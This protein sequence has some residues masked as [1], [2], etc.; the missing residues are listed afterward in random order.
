MKRF[1][2]TFTIL[3]LLAAPLPLRLVSAQEGCAASWSAKDYKSFVDVQGEIKKQFGE[4]RI[5]RVALCDKGGNP[6]FL[7][8]IISDSGEVRRVQL[9]AN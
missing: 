3:A 7:V 4:V 5:L 1:V 2:T 8:L 6:Y 9:A